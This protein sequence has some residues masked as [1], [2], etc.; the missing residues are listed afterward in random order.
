MNWYLRVKASVRA[1]RMFKQA[2][3][4]TE[5]SCVGCGQPLVTDL[6]WEDKNQLA[7]HAVGA[8]GRL[9]SPEELKDSPEL[10]GF[11]QSTE[12]IVCP[13]CGQ[14][15]LYRFKRPKG[16]HNAEVTPVDSAF[17]PNFTLPGSRKPD[18]FA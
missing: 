6:Y 9:T 3:P 13:H 5:L 15:H 8:D 18:V 17:R 12:S 10:A 11:E 14:A 7:H 2:D 4:H 1:A 16:K